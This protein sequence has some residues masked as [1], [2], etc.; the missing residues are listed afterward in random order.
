MQR[1]E[2][3]DLGPA[4][5][6]Q[7]MTVAAH[8]L[9][10]PIAVIKAS[11]QMAQRQMR[12]GDLEAAQGR[13]NAVVD[14]SDRLTELLETFLDAARITAGKLPLRI[15]SVD[16]QDIVT[17]AQ[18]RTRLLIGDSAERPV[19]VSVPDGCIGS[20]DR[21]RLTR[22]VRA[23]LANAVLYG[24]AAAPVRLHATRDGSRV[25]IRVSGGGPGPDTDEQAHLFERFFRGHSAAEAGQ[26]GSGLGLFTARGIAREHGGD[27]RRLE[28]DV[29][30]LELP[31]HT[32]P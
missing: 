19:D 18:A 10:N 24:D 21:A 5:A 22:A 17:A 28:A 8:D 4:I 1:D 14:Q 11:A 3:P 9:R 20:W 30:E 12:R 25:R 31:L 27:V 6:E 23:L 7:F 16:L 2:T 13:L 26:S 29:F 32:A 15:E